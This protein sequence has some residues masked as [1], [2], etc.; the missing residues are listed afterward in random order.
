MSTSSTPILRL[1]KSIRELRRQRGLTQSVLAQRAGVPRLSVLHAEQGKEGMAVGTL[2]R[3]LAA[4]NAE[5][6]VQP[7]RRPTLDEARQLFGP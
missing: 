5:F 7:A 4:L 6:A 2:A 1:A 3:I